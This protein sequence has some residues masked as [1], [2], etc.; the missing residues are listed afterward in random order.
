MRLPAADALSVLEKCR[1][2]RHTGA[3][4]LLSDLKVVRSSIDGYG[5]VAT[6]AFAPGEL[7]ADVDGF[8][9]RDEDGLDD[10]YS[11]W[12]D[13]GLY[14]DMVDQTRWINHSCDPNSAVETGVRADG[15]VWARIVALRPIAAGEEISYD[16]AFPAHLAEPC[17][18]GSHRC[19]GLI[20]DEDEI[21][22]R[23]AAGG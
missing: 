5:V 6:R 19:R 17:R 13:D 3:V 10:R 20:I 23:Q 8:A 15:V 11:L 4:P 9:W 22:A 18:C 16:Y 7:V 14:F 21:P 2:C 12:V 1:R